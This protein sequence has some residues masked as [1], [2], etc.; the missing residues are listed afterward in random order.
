MERVGP[1]HPSNWCFLP[2]ECPYAETT[3]RSM[4]GQLETYNPS[5][6]SMESL[7]MNVVH[8]D[9]TLMYAIGMKLM[10]QKRTFMPQ[11]TRLSGH[12]CCTKVI[13]SSPIDNSLL[14]YH[15]WCLSVSSSYHHHKI[16]FQR[17]I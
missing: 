7:C 3:V 13:V 4:L 8:C 1:V 16:R 10:R 9:A 5:P 2:D 14:D 15:Y 12:I 17:P 6:Q 11:E